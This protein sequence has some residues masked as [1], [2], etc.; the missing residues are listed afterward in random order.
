MNDARQPEVARPVSEGVRSPSPLVL[1]D[2]SGHLTDPRRPHERAG[3]P[4]SPPRPEVP[5]ADAPPADPP[6]RTEL[7]LEYLDALPYEPYPVQEEAIL[8]YFEHDPGVLVC[9]PTGTGKTL[10]AEAALFEA[11]HTGTVAYYTTPLIALTDQKF[12]E[13]QETAVRWGFSP[14]DVGLVTGNRTVN[15]HAKVRV[16]VA[17]ILMNRLLH[18]GAGAL[19]G[20][21]SNVKQTEVKPGS[22]FDF[23]DVSAVVMDE[24]HSFGDPERGIVWELSLALLPKHVRLLLL[25]ATVGNAADFV[26]WLNRSHGR[27]LRLVQG[28]ERKVPLAFHWV[29]DDLLTDLLERMSEGDVDAR[30][31]PA[32]LF[33]FNRDECWSVAETLKGKHLIDDARQKELTKELDEF[34]FTTGAGT[35]L[36]PILQRGVGVHH[37]GVLPKYKRLVEDLFQQ[38]LL[39]VVVCTETLA[40]GMNLPARS[41]ILTTLM[42]GPRGRKKIIDASGAHQMFGRAGRPQYDTEGNVYALAHEDDV[43]I[44]RWDAKHDLESLE[45]SNDPKVRA[46]AK[47]LKKKRPSRRSGEQYWNEDQYEKLVAAPPGKLASRGRL[48]W[49]LIAHLLALSPEVDRLRTVVRKRLMG[50]GAVETHLK[51]LDGMLVTLHRGGFVELEPPPPA[52]P[53]IEVRAEPEEAVEE[54]PEPEPEPEPGGLGLGGLLQEALAEAR[55]EPEEKAP[56]KPQAVGREETEEKSDAPDG[57]YSPTLARI[58]PRAVE[59]LRFRSVDPL[60]GS[61][62]LRHLG[63]AS[64][65]EWVQ[66]LESVL[67]FPGSAV[68]LCRVPQPEFM[69]PGPLATGFLDDELIARGLLSPA[70][71]YPNSEETEDPVTLGNEW[72]RRF[73]PTV[74]E[75]LHLLFGNEYPNAPEVRVTAVW[76]AGDL[77]QFGGD[78]EGYVTGRGLARQEGIVFRH[79]LRLVLLCGE[80]A[81]AVPDGRDPAEWRAEL[82]EVADA[83]TETCRRVDD[84]SVEETLEQASNPE[85]E[86][87]EF[88]WGLFE[89][90][91]A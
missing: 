50:S 32:L 34:H 64:R 85:G 21:V 37:A 38:K 52:P 10:I 41:V 59:L 89:G 3:R 40:A 5:I 30:K 19:G 25:S 76:C 55:N 43:K 13:I 74:A 56:A 48:P 27:G 7:A 9:A 6:D 15:P 46:A 44:A 86:K 23:S 83:L 36:K 16:V 63:R 57:P 2:A 54:K 72:E 18:G 73:A 22:V 62:L 29:E 58:R 53:K 31:T 24:F 35:K 87:E 70:E 78:F 65:E 91:P 82:D 11:L 4:D 49:R 68:K 20:D 79:L 90:L 77:L 67:E 17:E 47:R 1:A 12:T 51:E 84:R 26:I 33:C 75:K 14:D 88:G 39:A 28:T 45:K 69:P 61:F 8:A 81:K 66:V 80:F 71:L 42:K 60:Y